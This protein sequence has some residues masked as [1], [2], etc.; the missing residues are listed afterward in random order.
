MTAIK[1][2]QCSVKSRNHARAAVVFCV[3]ALQFISG[4]A[5]RKKTP[6]SWRGAGLSRPVVPATITAPKPRPLPD[7]SVDP[8]PELQLQLP[9]PPPLLAVRTSPARPHVAPAPVTENNADRP[10][11]PV[12]APQ[13][14]VA[15]ASAARQQMTS[16]ISEAEKNL[17]R[18]QGKTL[19]ATQSDLATKIKQFIGDAQ[20]A[21]R[22]GDWTRA[23]SLATKAQ[24][25]S[26]ELAS[27]L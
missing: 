15:E 18:S 8:V 3:C 20:S 12:I 7:E 16:S 23:R 24:V 9:P 19:N 2:Q 14:S 13:M 6:V 1:A 26:E 5:E 4:C 27:S 11:A 25:L 10:E 22:E 21:S 17:A